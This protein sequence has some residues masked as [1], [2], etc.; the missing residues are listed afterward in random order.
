MDSDEDNKHITQEQENVDK[1]IENIAN[2]NEGTTILN[3]TEGIPAV[4]KELGIEKTSD[5]TSKTVENTT[6]ENR[7]AEILKQNAE[8]NAK[9]ATKDTDAKKDEEN[10]AGN[11]VNGDKE[12]NKKEDPKDTDAKKDEENE[13]GNS[14]IGDQ[15]AI[16]TNNTESIP[17]VK[18]DIGIENTSDGTSE[19]VE[20]ATE[21]DKRAETLKQQTEAK[22]TE[23]PKDTDGKNKQDAESKLR[24]LPDQKDSMKSMCF[25]SKFYFSYVYSKFDSGFKK[26]PEI[27]ESI[28]RLKTKSESSYKFLNSENELNIYIRMGLKNHCVRGI[29]H[30]FFT[31]KSSRMCKTKTT[32]GHGTKQ[33]IVGNRENVQDFISTIRTNNY[34]RIELDYCKNDEKIVHKNSIFLNPQCLP[35]MDPNATGLTGNF[36]FENGDITGNFDEKG[37][38]KSK[39][40]NNIKSTL[41]GHQHTFD[42][43][44]DAEDITNESLLDAK[45]FESCMKHH[46]RML[47]ANSETKLEKLHILKQIIERETGYH[48]FYHFPILLCVLTILTS[49]SSLLLILFVFFRRKTQ[50]KP[51]YNLEEREGLKRCISKSNSE[52]SAIEPEYTEKKVKMSK[53]N[54]KFLGNTSSELNNGDDEHTKQDEESVFEKRNDANSEQG[55]HPN[56]DN[57]L[58]V[59]IVI[60]NTSEGTSESVENTK[61]DAEILMQQ[62]DANAT[63]K[64]KDKESE[65]ENS[66]NADQGTIKRT[67]KNEVLSTD[68]KTKFLE[69]NINDEMKHLSNEYDKRK[70]LEENNVERMESNEFENNNGN[71]SSLNNY[72]MQMKTILFY[73]SLLFLSFTSIILLSFL[74][75]R[76]DSHQEIRG[77]GGS[78]VNKIFSDKF[79]SW[80]DLGYF[81][82]DVNPVNLEDNVF[83]DFDLKEQENS[84]WHEETGQSKTYSYESVLDVNDDTIASF[85]NKNI[86]L[87][88][89]EIDKCS[90]GMVCDYKRLLKEEDI[91]N[92]VITSE[93]DSVYSDFLLFSILMFVFMNYVYSIVIVVKQI[94]N[95]FVPENINN[96]S[97]ISDSISKDNTQFIQITMEPMSIIM[98]NTQIDEN[99]EKKEIFIEKNVDVDTFSASNT[100]R[101]ETIDEEIPLSHSSTTNLNDFNLKRKEKSYT[102]CKNE[103]PDGETGGKFVRDQSFSL[104]K[105]KSNS[106]LLS[107]QLGSENNDFEKKLPSS[108]AIENEITKEAY[109]KAFSTFGID[110]E[111]NGKEDERSADL[112]SFRALGAEDL[113]APFALADRNLLPENLVK[114]RLSEPFR[115]LP[116]LGSLGARAKRPMDKP[117]LDESQCEFNE[118]IEKEKD[119]LEGGIVF[120]REHFDRHKR[121]SDSS[122]YFIQ[123]SQDTEDNENNQYTDEFKTDLEELDKEVEMQDEIPISDSTPLD[124]AE[125]T[126]QKKAESIKC[127][128]YEDRRE[129]EID[130]GKESK[131][132]KKEKVETRRKKLDFASIASQKKGQS[133]SRLRNIAKTSEKGSPNLLPN[134][135]IDEISIN[136]APNIHGISELQGVSTCTNMALPGHTSKTKGKN[137]NKE[138]N[139]KSRLRGNVESDISGKKLKSKERTKQEDIIP[140][141]SETTRQPTASEIGDISTSGLQKRKKRVK[142]SQ[143]MPLVCSS[144][145][146]IIEKSFTHRQETT[147]TATRKHRGR[148][149]NQAVDVILLQQGDMRFQF[150]MKEDMDYKFSFNTKPKL[151]SFGKVKSVVYNLNLEKKTH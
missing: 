49:A 95:T 44:F 72:L 61:Q 137:K 88:K 52:E 28:G 112:G 82:T 103:L 22:A 55:S 34:E 68:A 80:K 126:F 7:R 63:E 17:V 14:V 39:N 30:N 62:A 40:E 113:R 12:A 94:H 75:T 32:V 131:F 151:D 18:E 120:D 106:T 107:F 57:V 43:L 124:I 13:A 4:D 38:M 69:D 36:F 76:S 73:T 24:K 21:E 16:N 71:K 142:R 111:F 56:V 104:E 135:S 46:D 122:R 139:T 123:S 85:D 45:N 27:G 35:E 127:M 148:D 130:P 125:N 117:A 147:A 118:R 67:N 65:A 149:L 146:S 6:E 48:N 92:I 132:E 59:D 23:E 86:A 37:E 70:I 109:D 101:N 97:T 8:A 58:A 83:D 96:L 31:D 51:G 84:Q 78:V 99:Y 98:Q 15:G 5:G 134:D 105:E 143:E 138:E 3:N 93:I 54:E 136:D 150:A 110:R 53:N 47:P 9:E 129:L 33:G 115:T 121:F 91:S 74:C 145:D 81:Y 102:S 50:C 89:M 119:T 1:H 2:N 20:N 140:K 26:Y 90:Y 66:V 41:L 144:E 77:K 87:V 79:L 19:S 133:Y 64:P 116:G 141:T 10:K 11:S 25:S 128:S 100:L 108:D 42:S 60:E 114:S 29:L